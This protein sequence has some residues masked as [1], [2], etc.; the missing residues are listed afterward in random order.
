[1]VQSNIF[2]TQLACHNDSNASVI[3]AYSGGVMPYEI[4][5]QNNLSIDTINDLSPGIYFYSVIDS[6]QCE[7]LD[8]IE[9]LNIDN[10]TYA[11]MPESLQGREYESRYEFQKIDTRKYLLI[12]SSADSWNF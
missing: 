11:A 1:M 5:W 4:Y 6:N 9:I 2:I 3:L 12:A 8:T 7:L 10:C